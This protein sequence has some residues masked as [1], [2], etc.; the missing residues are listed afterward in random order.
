[1]T[2]KKLFGFVTASLLSLTGQSEA[3]TQSQHET[4][5]KTPNFKK[6]KTSMTNAAQKETSIP[7]VEIAPGLT[8]QQLEQ[9]NGEKPQAGDTVSVHYAGTLEDGTEFDN[10]FKRGQPIQFSL[11]TGQVIK[12][13]DLGIAE[14]SVGEKGILT[15][16]PE[17]GYG[18]HGAGGVIPGNATLVFEVELVAIN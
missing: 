17:L 3:R 1:M 4:T 12:G 7:S 11:G 10:S 8:Y 14:L 2:L 9:G 6:G 13:W 16:S 5:T 18:A 15:I